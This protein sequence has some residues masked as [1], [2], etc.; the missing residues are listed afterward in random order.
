MM[1]GSCSTQRR[2]RHTQHHSD[3]HTTDGTGNQQRR[4]YGGSSSRNRRRTEGRHRS[5]S[6]SSAVGRLCGASQVRVCS[7]LH[8]MIEFGC[9]ANRTFGRDVVCVACIENYEYVR[10]GLNVLVL[11]I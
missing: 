8:I 3:H 5:R 7:V 10:G 6:F 11:L 4:R 2:R 1:G 9:S